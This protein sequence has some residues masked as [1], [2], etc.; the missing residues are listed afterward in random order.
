M[1][2]ASIMHDGTEW[3]LIDCYIAL[4]QELSVAL[5]MN[6][7]QAKVIAELTIRRQ[8]MDEDSEFCQNCLCRRCEDST[9]RGISCATCTDGS[10]S[11]DEC[12]WRVV[13][14]E[15]EDDPRLGGMK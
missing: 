7:R 3:V 2:Y 13:A 5:E 12:E 4:K 14:L 10:E 8:T 11:P 15:P 1:A 6:A 9:C